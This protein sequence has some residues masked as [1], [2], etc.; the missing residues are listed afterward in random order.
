MLVSQAL[1]TSLAKQTTQ[2]EALSAMAISTLRTVTGSAEPARASR[3]NVFERPYDPADV[4]ADTAARDDD[5]AATTTTRTASHTTP[6]SPQCP[7]S[8][9]QHLPFV[10]GPQVTYYRCDGCGHL[11]AVADSGPFASPRLV[12][13]TR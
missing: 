8:L 1:T 10:R 11:F 6:R 5:A 9:L 3:A 7:R 12:R 2:N 13:R 4:Q